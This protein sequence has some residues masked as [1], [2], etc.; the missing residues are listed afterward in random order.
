[1]AGAERGNGKTGQVVG[2]EARRSDSEVE[3]AN[4]VEDTNDE[5]REVVDS[6]VR[7]VN[8]EIGEGEAEGDEEDI[9][10]KDDHE[11]G[12]GEEDVDKNGEAAD[13]EQ[14]S[15]SRDD[16]GIIGISEISQG[17]AQEEA[18]GQ[19]APK[20]LGNYTINNK[21]S[22]ARMNIFGHII[23]SPTEGVLRSALKYNIDQPRKKGRPCHTWCTDINTVIQRS[24]TPIEVWQDWAWDRCKMKCETKKLLSSMIESEYEDSSEGD[25]ESIPEILPSDFE[26]FSEGEE[27]I[28]EGFSDFED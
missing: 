12:N 9:V 4:R 19:L 28:L 22:A 7:G 1:M 13:G 27:S 23:R 10:S 3:E 16:N 5:A 20:L 17:V 15:S 18:M 26:G 14:S 24:G 11:A 2:E 6:E 25:C 21:I 8:G